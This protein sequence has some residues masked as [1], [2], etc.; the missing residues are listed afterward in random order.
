MKI[1][2]YPDKWTRNTAP[3]EKMNKMSNRPATEFDQWARNTAP[4]KEKDR[5]SSR[6]LK[7][8]A[9]N[10]GS[11]NVQTITT[12]LSENPQMIDDVWKT[13]VVSVEL[14]RLN[15]DIGSLHKT[16]IAG[17]GMLKEKDYTFF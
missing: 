12:S 10:L 5:K 4:N 8:P 9:L 11:W 3:E 16:Q 7:R 14:K 15:M 2:D 1:R 13:A 6:K 17:S